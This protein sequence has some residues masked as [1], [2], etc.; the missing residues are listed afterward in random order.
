MIAPPPESIQSQLGE[1]AC[2]VRGRPFDKKSLPSGRAG[3]PPG[4]RP[5]RAQVDGLVGP[6]IQ[7]P[8]ADVVSSSTQAAGPPVCTLN[9]CRPVPV[10]AG[11]GG[12]HRSF[13]GKMAWI[14][15]RNVTSR[16]NLRISRGADSPAGTAPGFAD[17][18][19]QPFQGGF[20]IRIELRD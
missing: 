15:F 5:W 11:T 6:S 19:L 12:C 13:A 20:E 9:R 14:N 1:A 7:R 10:Q 3:Y 18:P 17:S 16:A 2:R 8:S 4:G